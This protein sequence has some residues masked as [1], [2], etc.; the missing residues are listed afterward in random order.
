MNK[1]FYQIQS[2]IDDSTNL[3]DEIILTASKT[4]IINGTEAF[5]EENNARL[6]TYCKSAGLQLKVLRS[7][8]FFQFKISAQIC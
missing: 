7:N 4:V 3:P 1:Y 8:R 6:K 2:L 5:A